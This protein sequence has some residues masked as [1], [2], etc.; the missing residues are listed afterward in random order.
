MVEDVEMTVESNII[1]ELGSGRTS[2]DDGRYSGDAHSERLSESMSVA[3]MERVG[4]TPAMRSLGRLSPSEYP[5]RDPAER[6]SKSEHMELKPERPKR[7]TMPRRTTSRI[8]ASQIGLV[9]ARS[10]FERFDFAL[11]GFGGA[12][13]ELGG[14]RIDTITD[15]RRPEVDDEGP[16]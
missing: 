5:E 14:H 9:R 12:G 10:S 13:L 3:S 11:L 8:V 7:P 16:E 4:T 6:L 2:R 1:S 15:H